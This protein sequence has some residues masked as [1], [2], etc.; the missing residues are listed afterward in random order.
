M[1]DVGVVIKSF[2]TDIERHRTAINTLT[3]SL[4]RA[5]GSILILALIL[6]ISLWEIHLLEKELKKQK[7]TNE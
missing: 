4:K 1:T 5:H 3:K 7:D 2:A 6:G